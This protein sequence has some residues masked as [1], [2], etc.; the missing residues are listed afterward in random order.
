[1]KAL[2]RAL[3]TGAFVVLP[4]GAIVLLVLGIIT[5]LQEAV[6]PLSSRLGHPLL[7]A[8]AALVLLCAIVGMLI[9][10]AIGRRTR[11]ILEALLFEKIPGYRL[12]K[13]FA[14]DGPLVEGG[15]RTM[16]PALATIEDGQCPALVMDE[17]ADGRLLVFVPATPAPMSGAIYIFTRD[18]VT[19]LDV[20]LFAISSWGLGLR[21]MVEIR[22]DIHA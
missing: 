10:S 8:I 15:S 16:R 17:F 19:L 9:R 6:D 1:M 2:R 5:K 14:A 11:E 7:V 4:I 20:P 3:L 22:H 18:T 12:V 13:A 21:Q